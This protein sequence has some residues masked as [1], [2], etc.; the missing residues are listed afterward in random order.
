M[1]FKLALMLVL[2]GLVIVFVAQN[3]APV[4]I[5]FFY[6]RIE[7]SRALLIL[8]ALFVGFALGW[9]LHGYFEYRRS[10]RGPFYLP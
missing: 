8:L 1:K 7:M 5:G 10:N 4:D 3:V 6:W 2:S 9:F